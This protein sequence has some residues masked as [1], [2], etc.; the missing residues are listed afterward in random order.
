MND[1]EVLNILVEF[2]K[3]NV[4][5]HFKLKK[6]PEN[7]QVEGEYEL[8][9]P[10]VYKGWVPP[11][12]YLEE[13]GYDVPAIIV[14]LDDSID[15][16]QS[17]D[18][19][20]RLKIITYDPGEI[21]EDGKIIP[22]VLGYVDLLNVITKIR[23]EL[24]QNPIILEKVNI[25]KPIKWSMDK[26]QSYPYWSADLSFDVSIAPLAFNINNLNFL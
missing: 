16:N 17:A 6:P 12:N 26:E 25:N 14:I 4:A 20:I 23:M 7:N 10:A 8:V 15:D 22:N 18:I 21:K 3:S 5:A 19:S 24:S 9:N 13:Y 2:F 1:I 11:K